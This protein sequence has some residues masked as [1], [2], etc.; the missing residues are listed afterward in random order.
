MVQNLPPAS[1]SNIVLI[2][3]RPSLGNTADSDLK[4]NLSLTTTDVVNV[5]PVVESRSRLLV[6]QVPSRRSDGNRETS[7]HVPENCTGYYYTLVQIVFI[8]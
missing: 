1:F 8:V 3:P 2:M 7:C 4:T 6:A 5:K